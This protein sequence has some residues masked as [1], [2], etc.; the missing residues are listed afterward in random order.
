MSNNEKAGKRGSTSVW[1]TASVDQ[2]AEL[3]RLPPPLDPPGEGDGVMAVLAARRAPPLAGPPATERR[4]G[5]S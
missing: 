3:A 2:L 4:E 1:A 5:R